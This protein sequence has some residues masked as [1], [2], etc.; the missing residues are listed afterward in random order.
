VRFL[1]TGASGFIGSNLVRELSEAGCEVLPMVRSQGCPKDLERFA[2]VLRRASLQ[3]P[4]ALRRAVS[5]VDVVVHLGGLTRAR[6]EAEFM[7]TNAEG[8]ARLVRAA[9]EAAP[10]LRRFVYVSS[11]SAGGPSEGARPVR[12]DDPP[13][14]VSAYGRSK[15]AGEERLAAGAR[16]MPWTVLRPPIVYGPGERDLLTMFRY[17][18]A[19]FVPLLGAAERSYSVVHAR[20]LASAVLAVV[21]SDAARGQVYYVAEPRAYG[22]RELVA[23]IARAL[24]ARP[25]IVSIPR[26]LGSLVA[27][28]G[29]A[30]KRFVRRPP[31]ITLDKMPELTRSWVCSPAKIERDC[32]FRCSVAFPEGAAETAAW[33]RAEGWL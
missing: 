13:R 25:R 22:S 32:G 9:G 6:S 2:G 10:D 12:E 19:G 33:Y 31:L 7:D 5:G 21:D 26:A 29:S 8:V 16:G 4:E 23:H 20:D 28:A 17:A 11:L 18:R 14:P 15:L 24:G 30:A 3:D 1:V 27:A